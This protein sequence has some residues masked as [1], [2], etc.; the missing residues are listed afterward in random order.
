MKNVVLV[1]LKSNYN[2]VSPPL[3]IGYLL[4]ALSRVDGVNPLFVD[5]HRDNLSDDKLLEMLQNSNPILIGF[6]VYSIDYYN[7][8]S[9]LPHVHRVCPEALIIAG[10]PHVSGLPDK[11]LI[12][13]PTLDFVVNGEGE[14]T[15]QQLMHGLLNDA[16][17]D[18][19]QEIPNLVY[20]QGDRIVHNN[21]QFVDVKNYGAPDWKRLEPD[22]YPPIQHGTFH[23]SNRVVPLLTSRGCPY[24][25]TF[26]AGHLITGK[27]IRRR[28]LSDVIDEIEF[29]QSTYGYNE[30]I[31]EDENFTYYK[32]HVLD[33]AGE[34]EKRKIDCYFSFPNGI[35]L[36]RLDEEI[37]IALKK[38]GTYL[39]G[40]G[41]ESASPRILKS[42]KKNWD[43]D[44]VKQKIQMLKQHKIIVCGFFIFGFPDET[45]ADIELTINYALK[46]G[47][48]RAYIG[49][50]IPLPGSDDFNDLIQKGELILDQIDWRT[51][52][53]G[54]G[55]I[56]YHPSAISS[57]ELISL[58]RRATIKFYLRPGILFNF[59]LQILRPS[60]IKSLLFR[61]YK[62]FF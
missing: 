53:S 37:T 44:S 23:K 18:N 52:T 31:I 57:D 7:F 11:T 49:N 27:K 2:V 61:I 26:C 54:L 12:D 48:D 10:G 28:V 47:F 14:V 41:I 21:Q 59:L 19:I 13:N 56:P 58:M 50:Y 43:L 38:M 6:Q 46:S 36:D 15:I 25:C 30:F 32:E 62:L 1:R 20:R 45:K 55:K 8:S 34:I 3:G 40:L 29:L 35:R 33:F 39:V 5:C 60:S 4:K 42:I 9:I 16:L 51:Y 24:P 22:K 17:K